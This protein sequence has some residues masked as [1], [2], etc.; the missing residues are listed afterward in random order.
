MGVSKN[1]GSHGEAEVDVNHWIWGKIWHCLV[2]GLKPSEKYES[3]LGLIFPTEWEK[4]MFQTTN[5]NILEYGI[6]K[7]SSVLVMI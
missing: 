7:D 5:Q 2:G 6:V 1:G 3:Q 4:N